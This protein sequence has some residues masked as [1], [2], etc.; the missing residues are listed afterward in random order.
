MFSGR[1][2]NLARMRVGLS[3]KAL[4]ER[5]GV[6][7]DTVTRLVQRRHTPGSDTIER[8]ARAV[9]F[10][11]EFLFGDDPDEVDASAVSF[12]SFSKMRAVERDAALSAGT[13][14]LIVNSWVEARF[15]LP[16]ADLLDLSHET[17]PR[18]A[19]AYIRQHWGLGEQPVGSL[20]ALLEAKGIRLYSLSENTASVN[21]FSFWKGGKPFIFLNNFKTAESSRFDAAHELGHLVLHK[22]GD[23]KGVRSAEREANAF[24]SSFLMPDADVRAKMPR[25]ITVDVVIRTKVRWRVSAMALAH[26]LHAIGMVSDWQYKSICIELARRGFRSGEPNG[27]DRE[28]SVV[29]RKILRQLWSERVSKADIARDL[30]LPLQEL[31]GLIWSLTAPNEERTKP[32]VAELRVVE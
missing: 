2:L 13:L 20:L 1:R 7:H 11:E 22:H 27:I 4:A 15:G 29:W 10:P 17:D 19:A 6:D 9:G 23:P 5:A 31:E 8:L 16:D 25:P 30:D 28:T 32:P 14:G 18:L 12:R 24:A 3:A 26:R 21:A